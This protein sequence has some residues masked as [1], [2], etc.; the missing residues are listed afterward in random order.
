MNIQFYLAMLPNWYVLQKYKGK[1]GLELN[2]DDAI[3]F[4][5]RRYELI[6]NSSINQVIDILPEDIDLKEQLKSFTLMRMGVC[7]DPRLSAWFIEHEGDLFERNFKLVNWDYKK[8]ILDDL[9]DDNAWMEYDILKLDFDENIDKYIQ[10]TQATSY[11]AKYGARGMYK[12]RHIE[13]KGMNTIIAIDFRYAPFVVK[14]RKSFL[15]KGWVI[16]RLDKLMGVIKR[17]YENKVGDTLMNFAEKMERGSSTVKAINNEIHKFLLSKIHFKSNRENI[18]NFVINGEI[19]DHKDV[20]PPCIEDLLI[21]M[22]TSGYLGHWERLQLGIFLK[23][24]GMDV[25]E[26]LHFWYESAVDN[27]NMSFNDFNRKAGY[28]IRHI[29][30]LEGGKIDYQMPACSTIISKMYC[31]F[32]HKDVEYISEKV[33]VKLAQLEN[34][35]DRNIEAG[36]KVIETTN[37]LLPQI[38]CAHYLEMLSGVHVTKI[39][40]PL[41]YLKVLGKK[42]GL[43]TERKKDTENTDVEENYSENIDADENDEQILD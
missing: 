13:G 2:I 38:A 21:I 20:L 36:K 34:K 30:G 16:D 33:R 7:L 32:R 28:I 1:E 39:T 23:E 3:K 24:V 42:K 11:R 27:V 25:N 43:L 5:K 31:P 19:I 17:R 9:F 26:Q 35:T 4:V 41:F 12:Y 18:G 29:Y 10:A 15:Y 37:K 40:H 6:N 14:N 8:S 22:E